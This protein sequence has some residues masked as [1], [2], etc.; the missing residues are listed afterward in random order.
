M[1]LLEGKNLLLAIGDKVYGYATS[2]TLD[3]TVDTEETSSTTYKQMNTAGEGSW[4]K[5]SAAK[6]SWTCSTDHLV[7]TI[8]N[9]DAAFSA[10]VA[11]NPEVTIKFGSVTYTTGTGDNMTSAFDKGAAYTGKAIITSLNISGSTD[12]EATFSVSF[13]GTGE[14]T[15]A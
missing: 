14:L 5:F 2:A 7:G 3:V 6:K 15:K 8:D 4:K 12:G 9:F 10:I 11:T 1:S 13:Q